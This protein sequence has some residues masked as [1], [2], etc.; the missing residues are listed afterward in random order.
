MQKLSSV[1]NIISSSL[2]N[3]FRNI[4]VE[5]S[6]L[7]NLNCPSCI[8]A[9]RKC[10]FLKP[11]MLRKILLKL[12][13]KVEFVRLY[14]E[15][16]PTLSPHLPALTEM[17]KAF[18]VRSLVSTNMSIPL[19]RMYLRRVLNSVNVL[20][21]CVDGYNQESLTKYRV[22]SNFQNVIYNLSLIGAVPK[23]YATKIMSVLV[24]K[25][26][27]GHEQKFRDLAREFRF[28]YINWTLPIINWKTTLSNKEAYEWLAI[29]P[30]YQRYIKNNGVWVHNTKR[31]CFPEP[32]IC[33][34]GTVLGCCRDRYI[35]APIGNILN[36]DLGVLKRRLFKFWMNALARRY[37]FCREWCWNARNIIIEEKVA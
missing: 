23:C 18:G 2:K 25:H 30:K 14:G 16:E 4:A 33:V 17:L 6:D 12:D 21:C 37:S 31:L 20:K 5:P 19:D 1:Y 32:F 3:R 36:D 22:G 9:N 29:D 10:G 34:D 15:G 35:T 26:I 13:G 7:C 28:D 11:E 27:E 8:R 24:F